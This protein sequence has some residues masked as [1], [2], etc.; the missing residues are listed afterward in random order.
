MVTDVTFWGDVIVT[1]L[2]AAYS[3]KVFEPMYEEDGKEKS[4]AATAEKSEAMDTQ[5]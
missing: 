2:Q 4:A 5:S 3:D 1:P